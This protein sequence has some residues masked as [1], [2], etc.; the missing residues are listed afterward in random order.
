[1]RGESRLGEQACDVFD[2]GGVL[3][4]PESTTREIVEARTGFEPAYDGFANGRGA[5]WGGAAECVLGNCS[6]M[7]RT[8]SPAKFGLVCPRMGVHPGLHP[9][10]CATPIRGSGVGRRGQFSRVSSAD[11]RE[12]D[13]RLLR[14]KTSFSGSVF[15]PSGGGLAGTQHARDEGRGRRRV[16]T[17]SWITRVQHADQPPSAAGSPAPRA[18]RSR[19]SSRPSARCPQ[20]TG[21]ARVGAPSTRPRETTD[22]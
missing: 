14:T 2:E 13:G 6:A 8:P 11:D 9:A 4:L 7:P 18:T 5:V 12:L 17:D 16:G 19:T 3:V 20:S 15:S 21:R 10:A 1:M 22:P